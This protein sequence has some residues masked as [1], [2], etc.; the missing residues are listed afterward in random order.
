M[1]LTPSPATVVAIAA[2]VREVRGL[3]ALLL[4][5]SRARDDAHEGSDWDFGYLGSAD[6]DV[7]GLLGVLITAIGTDRVDLVDLARAGGLLRYRVARDG[8]VVV[9]PMPGTAD[10]F[11]LAAVQFWCDAGP[12]LQRGYEQVLAELGP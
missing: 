9:E 4:F 11:R 8:H 12:L 10:A 5:G 6:L 1:S 3:H 7:A 2:A